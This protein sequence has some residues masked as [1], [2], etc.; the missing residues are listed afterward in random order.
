VKYRFNFRYWLTGLALMAGATA[1]N[2]ACSGNACNV[3]VVR[4]DGQCLTV[5]NTSGQQTFV[6]WGMFSWTLAPGASGTAIVGGT[7]ISVVGNMTAVYYDRNPPAPGAGVPQKVFSVR[8]LSNET[9]KIEVRGGGPICEQNLGVHY[10]AA[11][12]TV[13]TVPAHMGFPVTLPSGD[14]SFIVCARY[15][16][17][18]SDGTRGWSSWYYGD[19][20][21]FG[22]ANPRTL[23]GPK[24]PDPREP[25]PAAPISESP[26]PQPS[27]RP[28]LPSGQALTTCECFYETKQ[29][30]QEPLPASNNLCQSGVQVPEDCRDEQRRIEYCQD[31]RGAGYAFRWICK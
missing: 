12:I 4:S 19:W 9:L 18:F 17:Q 20:N 11:V 5:T 7:C 8:N 3:T 30:P 15:E 29:G 13:T 25:S 22:C 2:A 27:T 26:P 14:T 23:C 31:E 28:L 24:F 10:G 1:A 21:S 16:K 6:R